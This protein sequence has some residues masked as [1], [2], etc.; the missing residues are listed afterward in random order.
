MT[1]MR[2]GPPDAHTDD[3]GIRV[4]DWQG[5]S[6]LSVTSIRRVV[7]TP[8]QLAAWQVN[9]ALEAGVEAVLAGPRD[10]ETPEELK[11][12]L[13]ARAHEVRDKAADLGKRV[14]AAADG[15][16]PLD[17]DLKPYLVQYQDALRSLRLKV[18]LQEAQVFNL[19]LGYAG[20]LD[21]LADR[22][23]RRCLVDLK[24]GKSLY[25]DHILQ[26]VGYTMG[27]FIGVRGVR[28]EAATKLLHSV[29][30]LAIL[31][32]SP[33]EWEWVEVRPAARTYE[34]FTRMVGT[35][36]WLMENP[37]IDPHIELRLAGKGT[38]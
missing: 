34:A 36:Q 24:T 23:E 10:G 8:F 2:S 1:F 30:T 3:Q 27:E 15:S 25:V 31:H 18:L 38:P 37:H 11:K 21:L 17:E 6:L 28:D 22:G 33:S 16:G 5:R 14:H 26:L 35:A 29:D 19:T 7:G 32:L 20:S 12:R 9:Q 13:R 4:Y